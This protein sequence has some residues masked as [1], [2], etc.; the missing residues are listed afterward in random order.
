MPRLDYSPISQFNAVNQ[1]HKLD[2]EAARKAEKQSRASREL[3]QAKARWK[4][5][6][7]L[8]AVRL[9]GGCMA[10][11]KTAGCAGVYQ[12]GHHI[13]PV[14]SH[15]R[16]DTDAN[17]LP[18]CDSCH[19]GPDGIHRNPKRSYACGDLIRGTEGGD[20]TSPLSPLVDSSSDGE[21]GR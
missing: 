20:D 4:K 9:G 13:E 12:C 6:T 15:G 21:G 16:K 5:I 19:L 18:V 11:H 14:G 2:E 10:S 7:K 17:C 1:R 3:R 8:K